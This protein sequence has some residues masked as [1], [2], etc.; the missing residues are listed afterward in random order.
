MVS[1]KCPRWSY[2]AGLLILLTIVG[3][4]PGSARGQGSLSQDFFSLNADWSQLIF[5]N[6]TGAPNGEI[7]R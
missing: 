7:P 1:V 2:R 4:I 5:D 6:A 3:L